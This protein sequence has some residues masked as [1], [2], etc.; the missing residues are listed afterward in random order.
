MIELKFDAE[1]LCASQ[2]SD[3]EKRELIQNLLDSMDNNQ[4]KID[5]VWDAYA[6]LSDKQ[7]KCIQDL[8]IDDMTDAAI[9]EEL[10]LR[11]TLNISK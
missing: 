4:I 11:K 6:S 2:L 9:E 7:M 5:T 3:S 8:V 1:E 10:N